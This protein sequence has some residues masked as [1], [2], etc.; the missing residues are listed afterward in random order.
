[1]SPMLF[2]CLLQVL[3][4]LDFFPSGVQRVA[5]ATAANMCKG[6]TSEHSQ[7][8][9]EAIPIL[10]NLLTYQVGVHNMDEVPNS[11]L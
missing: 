10:N 1:M 3:S 6:L 8:V 7:A 4:F 2:S 11:P 9:K 5:V